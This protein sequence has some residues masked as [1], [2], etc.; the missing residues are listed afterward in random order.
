LATP[1]CARS[2]TE[3]EMMECYSTASR[4]CRRPR[5]SLRNATFCAVLL[6]RQS[7]LAG[8][9]GAWCAAGVALWR[10]GYAPNFRGGPRRGAA[11]AAFVVLASSARPGRRAVAR[12]RL[13]WKRCKSCPKIPKSEEACT[14][15]EQQVSDQPRR[16]RGFGAV[17]RK[18]Q[19]RTARVRL[20]LARLGREAAG[21]ERKQDF[22][23][24]AAMGHPG[25]G[26]A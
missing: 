7:G 20:L 15:A 22:G 17:D 18:A 10:T 26:R 5:R 23:V 16:A 24:A 4:V 9:V 13:V 21:R 2:R 19:Q 25:Q 3:K 1:R 11:A 8:S 6:A 14:A 12:L